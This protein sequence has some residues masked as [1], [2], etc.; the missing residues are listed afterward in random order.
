LDRASPNTSL[1]L[2][3]NTLVQLTETKIV[4]YENLSLVA[5]KMDPLMKTKKECEK[6]KK[7][8]AKGKILTLSKDLMTEDGCVGAVQDTVKEFGR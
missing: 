1:Q 2:V 5:R 3:K 8:G 6:V 4:G 7:I